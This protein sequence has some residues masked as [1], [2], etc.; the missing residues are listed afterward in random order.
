[1]KVV[2]HPEFVSATSPVINLDY[3]QFVRGCHMGIFPSYYEPWGY[4]PMECIALGLP[5]VTTDLS[6]FGAYAQRHI[7]NHEERGILV[8]NRRTK[9]FDAAIDDLVEYLLHF[10]RL[11]RRERIELRNGVERLGELFDWSNLAKHYDE[12]HRL[13]L[14]RI[15]APRPGTLEVRLV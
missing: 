6:G 12:A 10:V 5:A 4:T 9:S 2:F 13:A 1:V 8:L 15:G 11:N 3:E 7:P 14:D